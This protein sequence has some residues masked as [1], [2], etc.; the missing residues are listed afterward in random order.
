M[1]SIEKAQKASKTPGNDKFSRINQL[2]EE[3]FSLVVD[4]LRRHSPRTV[5]EEMQSRGFCKDIA[6]ISLT[7]LLEKFRR[8]HVPIS[9]LISPY[10]VAKET[11]RLRRNVN[12]I[13][14]ITDLIDLQKERI[15]NM[16]IREE[17]K[18]LNESKTG[19]EIVR[20]GKL[21]SNYVDMSI[22]AGIFQKIAEDIKEDADCKQTDKGSILLMQA[23]MDNDIKSMVHH[24]IQNMIIDLEGQIEN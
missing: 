19:E 6:T 5:A 24:S 4:L 14:E 13:N 16:I 22:K 10:M 18:N 2:P 3:E 7:H 21:L 17:E 23:P 20:L 9:D 11:G 1:K 12:F 15:R 8:L